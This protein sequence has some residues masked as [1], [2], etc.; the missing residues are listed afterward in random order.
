MK[1]VPDSQTVVD[2]LYNDFND[3]VAFLDEGREISLRSTADENFRKTLL[4]TVASYFEHRITEDLS[5]F[6]DEYSSQNELIGSF[7]RNKAIYRQYHTLFSWKDTNANAFF[8]LF[9]EV[10]KQYMREEVRSDIALNQAVKAFLELGLD[11]N[12]LVHGNFGSFALEKT[13]KEIFDQYRQALVFVEAMPK[14]LRKYCDG[15]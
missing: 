5:V 13:S 2:K 7:L 1:S 14:Y 9:G 11:R 12:R 15:E 8:G 4:L 6:F 10:F 3:L